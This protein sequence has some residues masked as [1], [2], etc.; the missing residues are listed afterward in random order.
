MEARINGSTGH[1]FPQGNEHESCSNLPTKEVP[2][3]KKKEQSVK[4]MEK[5][6]QETLNYN[7]R[8]DGY[9]FGEADIEDKHEDYEKGM[10]EEEA[11]K[12]GPVDQYT[13]REAPMGDK[14]PGGEK[15]LENEP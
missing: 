3:K 6:A 10:D 1:H 14:H 9:G 4:E 13:F 12:Y 8:L 15:F 2:V 5:E 7:D 11:K